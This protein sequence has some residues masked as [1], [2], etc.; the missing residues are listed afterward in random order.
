M[1]GAVKAA[2]KEQARQKLSPEEIHDLKAVFDLFDED[3][4]G[5]IDPSEIDKVLTELGLKARNEIVG[6]MINDMRERGRPIDFD[7]FLEIICGRTGDAK[8]REGLGKIFSMYDNQGNG[9]IDF[10][11]FKHIA[12]EIGENL[13][14]DQILEMLHHTHILNKTE[15]S[16]GFSFEEF[17]RIVTTPKKYW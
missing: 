13:N 7:E 1:K 15:S 11:S 3:H 17:Y 16:S 12:K 6:H 14:D 10:E 4:G 5:S 8:T 9:Y 2:N